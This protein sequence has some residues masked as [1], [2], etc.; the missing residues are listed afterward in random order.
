ME[1]KQEEIDNE[2]YEQK[3]IRNSD[4]DKESEELKSKDDFSNDENSIKEKNENK[5]EE[6]NNDIENFN[7]NTSKLSEEEYKNLIETKVS[8]VQSKDFNK[9]SK[10]DNIQKEL[11]EI[12][13]KIEQE[14]INLRICK[15]RYEKKLK[16][17]RELQGKPTQ[18]TKEEKEKEKKKKKDRGF[19]SPISH[20]PGKNIEILENETKS[21][22]S[23]NKN[24]ITFQ[25]LTNEINILELTNQ[26]LKNQIFNMK[27]QKL[28]LLN[29][30]EN[31]KEE[32]KNLE[33]KLEQ[34]KINNEESKNKI[35]NNE[36]KE[37]I[38]N[39]IQQQKNFV[40]TRD[41]L[42]NEY[43]RIIEEYIK[44]EAERKKEQTKK[45]QILLFGSDSKNLIK[46]ANSKEIER[47]LKLLSADEISDRIPILEELI[48]KWKYTNKF[49]RHMIEKYIINSEKIKEAF[50]R[51]L[52]Y[53]DADNYN[54]LPIIFEKNN[55]QF[56]NID[57]FLSQLENN[58]N[59]KENEKINLENKIKNL[60]ND[61]IK[62]YELRDN[63]IK[64][65]KEK[66]EELNQG[67]EHLEK[68]INEKRDL[69]L[70]I[71]P[72]CDNYLLKLDSTNLS[73]FIYDKAQIEPNKKY[74]E[75]N[76][77]KFISN[78]EDYYKLI[79]MFDDDK[80]LKN[81]NEE[82]E[83]DRLRD[84]MKFKL[85]NFEKGKLLNKNLY[86]NMKSDVQ[87]GMDFDSI[88]KRSSELI[89]HQLSPLS[90]FKNKKC[91]KG[92]TKSSSVKI[93]TNKRF[94]KNS[95]ES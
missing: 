66:I 50:D 42:E 28:F 21:K 10:I 41:E 34:M 73:Q 17:Y 63:Y 83:I 91:E 31:V 48:N 33:K 46:G 2:N 64:E 90:N 74:N 81:D 44:R 78:V 3:E 27:K 6:S 24:T 19:F 47:Q 9:F 93:F 71:Q 20:K 68:E 85:E 30:R 25:G 4:E 61:R 18:L 49:K 29:Q 16:L 15:E 95:F 89:M 22:K 26:D 39:G 55:E 87:N 35:K 67:I 86:T 92:L 70:K 82:N 32:N 43:H 53:Y 80:N 38:E 77:N 8:K 11:Q 72:I 40:K 14:K 13:K 65:K 45:Q 12:T 79:L 5:N 7:N 84:E 59:E 58:V 69:F 56:N 75:I 60:T 76:V 1:K 62:S 23:L 37:S 52:K 36:L 51:I 88:I 57:K 94:D 54:E